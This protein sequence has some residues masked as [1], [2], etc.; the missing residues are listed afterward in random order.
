MSNEGLKRVERQIFD[1]SAVRRQVP[2]GEVASQRGESEFGAFAQARPVPGVDAETRA[3]RQQRPARPV[4]EPAFA[5]SPLWSPR[6]ESL[7]RRPASKL[8]VPLFALAGP[9]GRPPAT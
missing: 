9:Y 8:A 4:S 2:A 6:G 1:E 3:S 7:L 5:G